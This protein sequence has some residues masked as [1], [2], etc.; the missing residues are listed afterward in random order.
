[1]RTMILGGCALMLGSLT[2]AQDVGMG[3]REGDRGRFE[4][5][6]TLEIETPHVNWGAGWSG[7]PLRV[8]AVPSVQEGRTLVELAQRLPMELT[9]V[10]IDPAWDNN[11]WTMAFENNYGARAEQGDLQLVYSYLEE[12]LDGDKQFD[13]ILLPLHHGWE[14]LTERSR[15][16]LRERVEAG[17][18]LVLIRPFASHLSPLTP[19]G[20]VEESEEPAYRN[21][22]PGRE[23]GAWRLAADHY[24]TRGAP[25]ESFPFHLL[26]YYVTREAPGA[27][28]LARSESGIPVLAEDRRG[29]G[30]VVAFG[31]RNIGISWRMSMAA[32]AEPVD[33]YWEYFYSLL[34]RSL[35]YAAGK[36]PRETPSFNSPEASWRIRA[37][38]GEVVREG[39]GAPGG[40]EGLP[41]GRYFLEQLEADDWRISTLEVPQPDRVAS[42]VAS[43]RVLSEGGEAV[44]EFESSRDALVELL[45]GFGRVIGRA[46][47]SGGDGPKR[48]TLKVARPLTHGGFARVRAGTAVGKTPVRFA[49]S[50]R[51]WEDYE[52]IM[53]WYGPNSYQPWIPALDEQFRRIGITTLDDPERNFKIIGSVHDPIFGI[54][55]YRRAEYEKR[56]AEFLRTGDKGFL[57]RDISLNSPD[58][59]ERMRARFEQRVG[60]LV[61]LKPFAYYLADESSVTC[62]ADAFDVDWSPDDLSAFRRWLM[63]RYGTVTALNEAWGTEFRDWDA[64]LP[65]TTEEAQGHG[66][67]APWSEHRVFMEEVFIRAV[68]RAGEVAREFDPQA[69]ASFSGTQ[70]P[71]AHN[72]CNWYEINQVADYLQP[73]SGGNQDAM[74]HLFR[75][76]LRLTG[77]TGY[78]LVGDAVQEQVW[79]RLFYGHSG[80]SIFWHY[81]LLNPDLTMSA[82]GEGLAKAFGR[83]QAG[84]GRVF[85]NSSVLEDGVAIHF[86]MASIRG[87]WITDGRI[88]DRV[89]SANRTSRNFAELMKRRDAWVTELERRGVQFRFLAT[90][91]IEAGELSR[92]RTL[93][94]PYSIALS[95]REVEEIE[96]F[97]A[98]GGTVYV[99]DRTGKMDEKCRWRPSPVWERLPAN[100]SREGPGDVGVPRR[101]ASTV[102]GLTTVRSYED[103]RLTGF[104]PEAGTVIALPAAERPR[105]DLLR[106]G[107][108]SEEIEISPS[109]PLLLLERDSR[110]TLLEIDEDLELTLRD[111]RGL[112]VRRSVV[113]VRV[114]APD[115]RL[116]RHYSGNVEIR[117]GRGRFE[118]PF[119]LN[120]APGEWRVEARDAVSGLTAE[121]SIER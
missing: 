40:A 42:V 23:S 22:E 112:P 77:F 108:A 31:Y 15:D 91:Q 43:P 88:V 67:F 98:S 58:L 16:R 76:G 4:A 11:K 65:M 111:E 106:G 17:A 80:A 60:D 30:R 70:I 38:D 78:G 118:I 20:S 79:R 85:M 116:A 39:T 14:A 114:V 107:P 99:D 105:Y 97:A 2:Q 120:D 36:E 110:I 69:R 96:K 37:V 26:E 19:V 29:A 68:R 41:P 103:A 52:V 92:Y 48:V 121:R 75:P 66:N 104:L 74:H 61:P 12:E 47:S 1:M 62:Y 71:T 55:W 94:L 51:E 24:I 87:A 89:V 64:V 109:Q 46:T 8:L 32:K 113:A 5:P 44:V 45:D 28:I 18:G 53:P 95:D 9:T 101:F 117:D 63:P 57:T 21:R 90:P 54:Y 10:T 6:Y 33:A 7:P 81:T 50:S 86:S 82:Q 72:G 102:D 100:F 3:R 34:C 35:I 59:V 115:G 119:A 13:V 73:Y 49:A 25:V 93:I 27:R 84:V 83:I 56:K